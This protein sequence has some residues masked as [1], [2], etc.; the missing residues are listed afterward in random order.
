MHSAKP[1]MHT[2]THICPS[3]CARRSMCWLWLLAFGQHFSQH[4]FFSVLFN[5]LN[6]FTL[7]NLFFVFFFLLFT[8]FVHKVWK[9]AMPWASCKR[10]GIPWTLT[11]AGAQ[12]SVSLVDTLKHT[13]IFRMRLRKIYNTNTLPKSG[14]V[15]KKCTQNVGKA[16]LSSCGA[17]QNKCFWSY[18]YILLTQWST[19]KVLFSE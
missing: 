4:N 2:N 1:S 5:E 8:G 18:F 13:W 12:W 3:A 14:Q 11:V 19:F 6:L 7:F 10:W 16:P 15:V 9:I 17:S